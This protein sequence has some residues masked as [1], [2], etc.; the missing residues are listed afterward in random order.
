MQA[1]DAWQNVDSAEAGVAARLDWLV[2]LSG[3]HLG[4]AAARLPVA[5][6]SFRDCAL[7]EQ[8]WIQASRGYA[9]R[10]L[11]VEYQLTRVYE[12][13]S[14]RTFPA[15]R[16]HALSRVQP[17]Y[18]FGNHLTFVA[19]G[20]P[21]RSPVYSRA[22]DYELEL[23]F[24]LAKPLVDATPEEALE[25]IG[26]FV[27]VND[28]SARDVQ[29]QEM[30]SGLGPQKC[31]HFASSMSDTLVTADEILPQVERLTGAVELN[32]TIVARTS[33]ADM[34]PSLGDVLAHLSKSEPLFAGELIATGTLPN[35]SGMEN[36]HWPM[37]GDTLR[38][39]IDQIGEIVHEIQ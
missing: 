37:P 22:L 9:R 20:A 7:F 36:G 3:E 5:P 28:W 1:Q 8:H 26:G 30:R 39:V 29:R 18:Y 21:M 14:R 17:L 12:T 23:G 33:T 16:L 25:A 6:R 10:F 4:P 31:K 13:L 15:F 35:G 24:V 32:G 34:R 2:P 38:L 19:S 27:V 11:P